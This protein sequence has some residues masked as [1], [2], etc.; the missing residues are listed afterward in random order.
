MARFVLLLLG[1]TATL[2]TARASSVLGLTATLSAR[3]SSAVPPSLTPAAAAAEADAAAA[4]AAEARALARS[5]NQQETE[6][7]VVSAVLTYWDPLL[8][9]LGNFAL[10]IAV[11][12]LTYAVC[13]KLPQLESKSYES[14]FNVPWSSSSSSSGSASSVVD[15]DDGSGECSV[16]RRLAYA[17]ALRAA[18]LPSKLIQPFIEQS[19][20]TH[21]REL[22]L[23]NESE[24]KALIIQVG[25]KS[26]VRAQF[27]AH[28]IAKS[29]SATPTVPKFR[30]YCT[31]Q[32]D[33]LKAA[34]LPIALR[35]AFVKEAQLSSD[36][37]AQL[38]GASV[39]DLVAIAKDAGVVA[40]MKATAVGKALHEVAMHQ[41]QVE[42][43]LPAASLSEL[44]SLPSRGVVPPVAGTRHLARQESAM[45]AIP[46]DAAQ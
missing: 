20:L 7:K 31:T 45:R 30:G 10:F 18:K 12:A 14:R 9:N 3:A 16:T 2:S 39:D 23:I 4:A 25:L 8:A 37:L 27:I 24:I 36:W 15:A 42:S 40:P 19:G 11:G 13:W 35:D 17:A 41:H 26:K 33:A 44:A 43:A 22:G 21:V 38:K 6:A 29:A 32:R 28:A 1:L 5:R 46:E 34:L